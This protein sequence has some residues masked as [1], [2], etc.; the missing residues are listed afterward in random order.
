MNL[1]ADSVSRT[2]G[3]FND[4]SGS[5]YLTVTWFG[6]DVSNPGYR[7]WVSDAWKRFHY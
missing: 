1:Y 4:T 6:R 3:P 5:A 7:T 2:S